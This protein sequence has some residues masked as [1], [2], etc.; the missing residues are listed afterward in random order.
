MKRFLCTLGIGIAAWALPGASRVQ[1]A[2]I[3]SKTVAVPFAF[4]IDKLTLPAGSYRVEQN[5]GKQMVFIVNVQTGHRVPM[6]REQPSDHA[7]ATTLTF[8]KNGQVYKLS[9]IS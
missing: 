1:A 8:E 7:G 4:K 6:M 2:D 9:R 3:Q 5:I